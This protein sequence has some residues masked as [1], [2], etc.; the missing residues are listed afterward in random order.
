MLSYYRDL[1]R[2]GLPIFIGF[3]KLEYTYQ[4]IVVSKKSREVKVLALDGAKK[5]ITSADQMQ[6][7]LV[8]NYIVA[9][10]KVSD[11][12]LLITKLLETDVAQQVFNRIYKTV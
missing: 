12:I 4:E 10:N 1:N 3:A 11:Q 8:E 7:F 2:G 5:I 9:D 6:K